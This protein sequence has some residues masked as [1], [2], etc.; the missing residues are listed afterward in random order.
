[1]PNVIIELLVD[2]V[3]LV[4]EGA[5]SAAFVEL[6]KRREKTQMTTDEIL[7]QLEPEHAEVI[8]T[9]LK[10]TAEALEKSKAENEDLAKAKEEADATAEQLGKEK[11]EL[12]AKVPCECDGEADETGTCKTCGKKKLAKAGGVAGMDEEETLKGLSDSAK[13]YVEKLKLQA[14]AAEAAVRKANEVQA[15]EM[16][17]A[18]AA[19]LKSLPVKEDDLI[20][21]LKGAD[22]KLVDMLTTI[23]TAIDATVLTEIGKASHNTTGDA[24]AAWSK[25]EAEAS[26]IE[27]TAGVTK[28]KAIALAIEAKPELYKEY[29]KGGSN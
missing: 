21:I 16:A 12:E 15:V 19:T 4:E 11:A 9:A 27:K 29:L 3:D 28:Q 7:S 18:R 26:K 14:T 10:E 8:K 24:D 17:K 13:A 1:M 23:S 6:F 2:R 5:N 25:I 20:E 22:E